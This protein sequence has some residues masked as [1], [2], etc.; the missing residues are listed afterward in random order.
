MLLG[1]WQN[2]FNA[3][4][5]TTGKFNVDKNTMV[6]VPMMYRTGQYNNYRDT[7]LPCTVVELPYKDKASMIIA[8]AEPGKIH[9]VEQGLSAETIQRWRTSWSKS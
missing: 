3:A 8:M 5:T 9:E 6:D 7:E 2:T 1:E 4:L